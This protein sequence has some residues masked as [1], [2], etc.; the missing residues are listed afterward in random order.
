MGCLDDATF[1]AFAAAQLPAEALA[2]AEAHASTCASCRERLVT[3][4]TIAGAGSPPA[5]PARAH[6]PGTTIGRYTVLGLVGRG[7]M[8]EVYAAYDPSLDRRVALKLL[9][10]EGVAR[11]D[12]AQD[13]LLREA[14]AIAKLSHPNVVVVHDMG[15]FDGRIAVAMEFIEGQ[16]LAAWLAA[17]RRPWREIVRV[18][19]QA[20]RGLSAA[21]KAGLVHRDFKPQNV[22]LGADG[23]VRVMDFGIALPLG[24]LPRPG[25]PASP[26]AN[27][28]GPADAAASLTLT[29]DVLGTPLFMAPEQFLGGAVDARADQF[30]FCVALYWAL[31]GVHPFG[32]Q[33][34]AEMAATAAGGN[35]AAPAR[36]GGAPAWVE[37]VLTRGLRADPGARWPSMDELVAALEWDPRRRRQTAAVILA[38]AVALAAAIVAGVRVTGRGEIACTDGA[39]R[40]AGVW[41]PSGG[42]GSRREAVRAAILG[43]G[44][45]EPAKTWERVATLLDRHVGRWLGG[46]REACA[47]TRLRGEQSAEA[48]DLRMACLNDSLDSTGALTRLL[49]GGEPAVIEHAVDAAGALGDLERCGDVE[50]LRRGVRPPKDPM[51]RRAVAESQRRLKEGDA[52]FDAGQFDKAKAI[53][54]SVLARPETRG[55]CPLQAEALR[56][57]AYALSYVTPRAGLEVG[58][59]AVLTAESCGDDLVVVEAAIS[60][61]Y[62]NSRLDPKVAEHWL[63]LGTAALERVGGNAR[64][65]S[66]LLNNLGAVRLN[67]GRYEE[68]RDALVRALDLKERTLGRDHPDVALSLLTLEGVLTKLRRLDEALADANR[69]IEIDA[70]WLPEDSV[71]LGMALSNR[72]DVLVAM[73]RLDEARRDYERAEKIVEP[74]YPSDSVDRVIPQMGLGNVALARGEL[75]RAIEVFER[76]LEVRRT[77]DASPADVAETR[78][79]LAVALDRAHRDPARALTLAKQ[80]LE[81]YGAGPGFVSERATVRAWLAAGDAAAEK[82]R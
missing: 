51:V 41:E 9:H 3:S 39:A 13:R 49:A 27:G 45:G 22:M 78:F 79:S 58:E 12:R 35:V 48:L 47:A 28:A 17:E 5:A 26:L 81:A 61:A 74:R 40:L 65:E 24:A 60:L 31:Y 10:A 1:L 77:G 29:G 44:T 67:Q 30:S 14:K 71:F 66:W 52:L 19:V 25:E 68:A 53:A 8:G 42:A 75:A 2:V 7:G 73:G 46:Y 43:S 34:R 18:F 59:K 38:G 6:A 55:Y 82:T 80:A 4:S 69:T 63:R 72:A 57:D 20:G 37:R 64:L 36:R 54:E 21:H 76:V 23:Q 33:T 15:T 11:D 62:M 70:R 56:L 32:G 16:T 50:Q